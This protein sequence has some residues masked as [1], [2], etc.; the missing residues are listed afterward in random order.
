MGQVVLENGVK[1]WAFGYAQYVKA[2]VIN[3]EE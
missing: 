3:V 1:K 2:D